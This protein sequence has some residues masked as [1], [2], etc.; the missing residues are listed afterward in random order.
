MVD[1]EPN[2]PT[3]TNDLNLTQPQE[4]S[5]TLKSPVEVPKSM[6]QDTDNSLGL[7]I[8]LDAPSLPSQPSQPASQQN[9]NQQNGNQQNGTDENPL[10]ATAMGDADIDSM[11][12]DLEKGSADS[13]LNLDLGLSTADIGTASDDLFGDVNFDEITTSEDLNSLM[14]GLENIVKDDDNDLTIPNVAT[15]NMI[16]AP[17][18][19]TTTAATTTEAQNP[20]TTANNINGTSDQAMQNE[21]AAAPPPPIPPMED[22]PLSATAPLDSNFDDLF[23]DSNFSFEGI[24]D[25][26]MGGDSSM[27]DLGDLEDWLKGD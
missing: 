10:S 8:T 9:G 17:P 26:D 23:T 13:T 24:G 14:P 1:D 11:F 22:Q 5:E 18:A 19:P 15:A 7:A 20:A 2:G 3:S 21:T 16:A 4:N 6:P 25:N 12:A 27:G